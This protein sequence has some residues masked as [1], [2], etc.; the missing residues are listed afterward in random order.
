MYLTK[1]I[2]NFDNNYERN[3]VK[4]HFG[5][6]IRIPNRI[7]KWETSITTLKLPFTFKNFYYCLRG[8]MITSH[9]KL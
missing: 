3:V 4:F 6:T 1:I 7:P 8:K 9:R 2:T 5:K